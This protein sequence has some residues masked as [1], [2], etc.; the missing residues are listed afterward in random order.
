MSKQYRQMGR[1]SDLVQVVRKERGVWDGIEA[2]K[3]G[4]R[5]LRDV[6]GFD[7]GNEKLQLPNVGC[8]YIE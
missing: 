3:K 2:G 1:Y 6:L 4:R 7:I 8:I 5:T